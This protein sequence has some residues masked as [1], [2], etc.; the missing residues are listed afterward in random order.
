MKKIILILMCISFILP[1]STTNT[2]ALDYTEIEYLENGCYIITTI[3][4]ENT[5]R[6][7]KTKTGTKT[8]NFYNDNNQ[9]MWSVSVRGT[10]TYTGS[11]SKCTSS[12]VSTTCPGSTWKI[13]SRN[14][15]KNGNKATAT[16]TAGQ[17]I[18]G[19]LSYKVSTSVTLTCSA[20]GK[21]S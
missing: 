21:L 19:Q 12:T 20:S 6:S 8:K 11:S 3:K 17:Y 13:L 1:F 5:L 2:S 9:V 7:T 15:S 4:E 10:F 18:G 14:A 16:A